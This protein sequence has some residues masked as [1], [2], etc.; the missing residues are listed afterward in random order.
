MITFFK[1]V[2]LL[3]IGNVVFQFKKKLTKFEHKLDFESEN[4]ITNFTVVSCLLISA[5]AYK[6]ESIIIILHMNCSAIYQ[7]LNKFAIFEMSH[8]RVRG[9]I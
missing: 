9:G 6:M 7:N 2:L 3:L 1:N 5:S 4:K 8:I